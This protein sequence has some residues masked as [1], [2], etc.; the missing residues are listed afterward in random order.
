MGLFLDF[1]LVAAL[2]IYAAIAGGMLAFL[3]WGRRTGRRHFE[4]TQQTTRVRVSAVEASLYALFGLLLAFTFSGAAERFGS[5]R[6]LAQDEV[7]A[8]AAA[9]K[10]L[11]HL[12]E[13]GRTRLREFVHRHATENARSYTE[14]RSLTQFRDDMRRLGEMEKDIWTEALDVLRQP[15][16]APVTM[17]VTGALLALFEKRMARADAIEKHPPLLIYGMLLALGWV[18]AFLSGFGM[19]EAKTRSWTHVAAYVGIVSLTM[20]IIVDLEFPR[21]GLIRVDDGALQAFIQTMK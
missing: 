9:W 4:R 5:R 19:A 8:V 20:Y 11:D 18:C 16:V 10:R 13:P 21:L 12:P 2:L 14:M 1:P 7:R 3:E 17:P 15:G 6:A